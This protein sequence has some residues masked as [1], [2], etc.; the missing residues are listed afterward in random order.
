MASCIEAR[1]AHNTKATKGEILSDTLLRQR[2]Q[3]LYTSNSCWVNSDHKSTEAQQ[4]AR[5]QS[6]AWERLTVAYQKLHLINGCLDHS[7]HLRC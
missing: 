3:T 6:V 4:K 5:E 2:Y 7:R 1:T